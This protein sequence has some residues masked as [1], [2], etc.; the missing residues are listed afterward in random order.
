MNVFLG[1]KARTSN[2]LTCHAWVEHSKFHKRKW[3]TLRHLKCWYSDSN[4]IYLECI[5][6]QDAWRPLKE[7][8]PL[9]ICAAPHWLISLGSLYDTKR[10]EY[11]S[12]AKLWVGSSNSFAKF[13]MHPSTLKWF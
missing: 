12:Y 9:C 13:Y 4:G 7:E 6:D 10:H 1:S 8:I 11:D 3:E 5:G 2:K